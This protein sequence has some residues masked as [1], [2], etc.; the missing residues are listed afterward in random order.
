MLATEIPLPRA[1]LRETA[2]H[3][4]RG[5]AP[6]TFHGP[7]LRD[8]HALRESVPD[9]MSRYGRAAWLG[10]VPS[11]P[12]P[13]S[14]PPHAT[15]S[16]AYFKM[17]EI[18]DS[19]A[20][21]FPSTSLHLCE[22]PGGF[23]Q[24]LGDH[25]PQRNEWSWS[26]LSLPSGP[27]FARSLL[28]LDRGTLVEG[29]VATARFEAGSFD[30]V[31][32]D[33]AAGMDH[34]QIEEE[35]YPLLAQQTQTAFGA[36]RNGGDMVVKFF[37]GGRSETVG[38]VASLTTCFST[39]SVIKPH[40]SRPTNSELY[41]VCR[42][43]LSAEPLPRFP[44]FVCSAWVAEVALVFDRLACRQAEA[45]R[46]TIAR[47]RGIRPSIPLDVGEDARDVV[48]GAGIDGVLFLQ[49]FED[50]VP[51]NVGDGVGGEAEL[52]QA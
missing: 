5:L 37:Q 47:L 43:K 25:H 28:P 29:D 45:L 38:W 7:G 44:F 14:A 32:A 46:R 16:R 11:P 39:V 24:W 31:T 12:F 18:F 33:G 9:V 15:C 17:G 34:S 41:L 27:A 1:P 36:L 4:E 49:P 50:R 52:P 6:R 21:P 26:A 48:K 20:L 10:A 13:V 3:P 19:C 42:G 35:H 2:V 30:L 8:A 51:A 23:V 22:A 40:T